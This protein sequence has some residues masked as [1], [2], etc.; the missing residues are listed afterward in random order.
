MHRRHSRVS[1]PPQRLQKFL[2]SQG[3]GSRREIERQIEAGRI[4]VNGKAARL[5]DKVTGGERFELDGRRLHLN[6]TAS[7]RTRVIRYHKA[8]GKVC[9]RSDEKGRD[10]VFDDLPKLSRGRW[11]AVGRLDIST[12]GLLLFTDNGELANR[13][14]HPRYGVVRVYS[15]RVMG[16]ASPAVLNALQQGVELED[17]RARFDT[18]RDVGGEG[19][20]HWYEVSLLEGRNREVRRL[21]E[22]Q[23]LRVSR[24]IRIGYGN[25]NLPRWLRPS[26]FQALTDDEVAAL[27]QLVDLPPESRGSA[28]KKTRARR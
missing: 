7:Q 28:R 4:K 19:L 5:G 24:L 22:S 15:S 17:G 16:T 21:W 3:V 6:Q 20:N 13:L 14:M 25:V 26:K 11:I 2:A 1:T 27:R 8:A 12:S 10:T 23:Q 18:I 9:T